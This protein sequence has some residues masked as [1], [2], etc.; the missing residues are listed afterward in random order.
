MVKEATATGSLEVG[1][2]EGRRKYN[3]SFLLE[4]HLKTDVDSIHRIKKAVTFL[5]MKEHQIYHRLTLDSTARIKKGANF[6]KTTR[7]KCTIN[8]RLFFSLIIDSLSCHF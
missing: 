8:E 1:L 4:F 5:K 6:L 7:I 2:L 3:V